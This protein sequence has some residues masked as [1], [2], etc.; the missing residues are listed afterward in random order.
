MAGLAGLAPAV[1]L[2]WL[3]GMNFVGWLGAWFAHDWGAWLAGVL[4]AVALGFGYAALWSG[5]VARQP[6][7]RKLSLPGTG[8]LYGVVAGLVTATVVALLL[9]AAAGDPGI[10]HAGFGDVFVRGFGGRVVPGLPDLGFDPPLRSLADR[11]WVS[12]NS[13]GAR[14]L[15]F[16]LAFAAFGATLGLLA[17]GRGK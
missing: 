7:A 13:H 9:S 4:I 12:R 1:V 14:L 10:V 6:W 17:P 3:M 8:A 16:A 5:F 15:P 11:D 2:F